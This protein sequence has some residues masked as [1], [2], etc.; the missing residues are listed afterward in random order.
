MKSL[1][2]YATTS[3]RWL[4][5]LAVFAWMVPTTVQ[6]QSE[7]DA[8]RFSQRAPATGARLIGLGGA[9]IAGLADWS[10]LFSNPAGLGWLRKSQAVGT[11]NTF[12]TTDD[13]LFLG[14]FQDQTSN[15]TRLSNLAYVHKTPTARGSMVFGIGFNQTG[16]FGRELFFSGQN[17]QNSITDYFMPLPDEF[18]I[19]FSDDGEVTVDFFRP[20][21]FIAYETYGIDFDQGL[22]DDGVDVPFLP[23]VT[24]GTVEQTG[25]VFE[26]GS[27]NELSFGGAIEAARGVMLG[28]GANLTFSN[29]RFERVFEEFDIND[30]NDGTNGTTDFNALTLIEDIDTDLVG[31]NVRGGLSARVL[32]Q[33]RVGL[34]LETPTY[35]SVD[36]T[37]SS[38]LN[39]EFDNG[40]TYAEEDF[41]AND[42][43]I[44][45]PWRFGAGVAFEQSGLLVSADIEMID[46]SQLRLEAGDGFDDFVFDDVNR[47]IRRNFDSVVNTRVGV[48]YQFGPVAV[49]GG[50]AVQPDPAET[51]VL[52]RKREFVSAGVGFSVQDQLQI[53]LGWMRGEF[54]DQYQPYTEVNNAP[55]VQEEITQN[56][57]AVGVQVSF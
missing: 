2:T 49:R 56:R 10:A 54:S 24:A 55:I 14:Q 17:E 44:S 38:R 25:D 23:A 50:Y 30:A 6:A 51:A 27:M 46:W 22:Y 3:T 53:N 7:E 34:T 40:D 39:T 9:G 19:S 47:R 35:Y 16:T 31:I 29:Y 32:P 12:S 52:D 5:F 42:Y 36:E 57:F 4:F 13:G 11:L 18:D 37:F 26:E 8:L 45:T 33:L 43:H 1:Y 48:E 41:G 20:I 28:V 21:S 15:R